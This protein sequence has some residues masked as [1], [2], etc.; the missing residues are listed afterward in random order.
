MLLLKKKNEY[1]NPSLKIN[2]TNS[3]NYQTLYYKDEYSTIKF[4][5]VYQNEITKNI[6]EKIYNRNGSIK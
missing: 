5:N 6:N 2:N 3:K 1:E 4:D